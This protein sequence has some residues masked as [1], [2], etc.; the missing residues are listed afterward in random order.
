MLSLLDPFRLARTLA[1]A[2]LRA[3]RLGGDAVRIAGGL[4]SDL[5]DDLLGVLRAQRTVARFEQ[6]AEDAMPAGATPPAPASAPPRQA[7]APRRRPDAKPGRRA[8][9]AAEP[10]RPAPPDSQAP[11]TRSAATE[12]PPAAGDAA[13]EPEREEERAERHREEERLVAAVADPGA[14]DGAGAEVQVEQPWR[15]YSRMRAADIIDRLGA[16]PE[17]VV[18]VAMLYERAHR[19]RR[20]VL[21]AAE[22]QLARRSAAAYPSR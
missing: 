13:S 22:R 8:D 11:A 21:D 17:A 9:H 7:Q 3:V 5:S 12:E 4:A 2:G 16:E 1:I 19:R 6:R 14:E 15:G 20:T 18:S 10:W